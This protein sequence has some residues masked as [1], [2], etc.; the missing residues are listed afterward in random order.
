MSDAQFPGDLSFDGP[1]IYCIRVRGI[2]PAHWSHRFGDLE[3]VVDAGSGRPPVTVLTGQLADQAGLTGVLVGLY[4]LH[5][6][7]LSVDCLSG[8][9]PSSEPKAGG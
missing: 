2:I 8:S 5:L 6:P 1:A 7:V 4:E 9:S 3:I